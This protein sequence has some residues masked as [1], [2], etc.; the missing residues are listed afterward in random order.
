MFESGDR[1]RK[2]IQIDPTKVEADGDHRIPLAVRVDDVFNKTHTTLDVVSIEVDAK[3][4]R[5]YFELSAL[6]RSNL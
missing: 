5:K 1:L 2:V 3:V 6:E 4:P